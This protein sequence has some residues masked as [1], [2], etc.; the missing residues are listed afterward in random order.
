[1]TIVEDNLGTTDGRMRL[2]LPD[3]VEVVLTNLKEYK[4]FDANVNGLAA[5]FATFT[6]LSVACGI[7][8]QMVFSFVQDAV[9]QT[10]AAI[11]FTI[12]DLDKGTQGRCGESVHVTSYTDYS[13]YPTL[14]SSSIIFTDDWFVAI[15][16]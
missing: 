12:A 15:R 6:Q 9:P 8:V 16:N 7:S 3:G 1:M 2:G 4:P 14:V 13:L 11:N 5:D 10:L